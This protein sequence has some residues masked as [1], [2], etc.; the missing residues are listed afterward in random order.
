MDQNR[1]NSMPPWAQ[2][3]DGYGRRHWR[4]EKSYN[5]YRSEAIMAIIFSLVFLYIV[6]KI[7]DWNLRFIKESYGA[8]LWIL[9]VN[10]LIQIGGNLLISAFRFSWI[11]YFSR[12]FMEGASLV[13]SLTLFYIYPFDFSNYYGLGW[14]DW[15]IPIALVIG[16]VVSGLKVISNFWKLIFWRDQSGN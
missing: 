2:K 8:V 12:I 13:T 4:K 3:V 15:F 5:R 7:P 14:L 16:M 6:N 11:R 1:D 10:L 9:N